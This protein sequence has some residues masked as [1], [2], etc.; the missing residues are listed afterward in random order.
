MAGYISMNQYDANIRIPGFLG[1]YQDGDQT[2][3]DPRY[4]VEAV[5]TQTP[6]GVLQP[7]ARSVALPAPASFAI[8]TL[9][10]LHRR[11]PPAGGERDILVGALAGSFWWTTK[12]GAAWN[13]VGGA[14]GFASNVWSWASY[15]INPEGSANP[16]DVLLLSNAQ[17]GMVMIRGDTMTA[18]RVGTPKRFGVISR[19]SERVW[20]GA[21]ADDPD[22][23]VYSAPF[24]PLDWSANPALPADGAGDVAQPSWDG[25]SFTAI[26]QFGAQL[27][28]FKKH[29]VWRI[30][31]TDPGEYVFREQYGG[32][33]VYARTVEPAG[34]M[35]LMLSEDGLLAYDGL[36]VG[37]YYQQN[38]R[39]VWQRMHRDALERACACVYKEKYFCALPLDGS[40]INNAV[41]VLDFQ[42]KTW[43][44]HEGVYV[45]DFLPTEDALFFTDAAAPS[46]IRRWVEDVWLD[47]G[48][49]ALPCRWVGPWLDLGKKHIRYGGWK[50]YVTVESRKPV[51]LRVTIRTEKKGKTKVYRAMP[52]AAGRGPKMKALQFGGSGRRFRLELESVGN[53][54]WR[55]IGGVQV[56]VEL[57][58]D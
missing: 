39:A 40:M 28:A 6:G 8:E 12:A 33:A 51:D 45:A 23:L 48:A 13:S 50:V 56:D 18:Q 14:G 41:L 52:P 37:P 58:P 32:G 27:L 35:V 49:V 30:L 44:L 15:E 34:E 2:N 1:L 26:L 55:M 9:A 46:Y 5:N 47:E 24:D 43:L 17:D 36:S 42:E 31:G 4:A 10:L 57:D 3:L 19:Y 11:W 7:A 38:A 16:V 22:M 53:V 21:I 29:R 20:G 25:D 54:P